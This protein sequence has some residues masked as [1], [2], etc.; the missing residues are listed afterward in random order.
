L[1]QIGVAREDTDDADR[2]FAGL[3]FIVLKTCRTELEK[4]GSLRR[5]VAKCRLYRTDAFCGLRTI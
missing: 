4:L 3:S 1:I 2:V 5:P